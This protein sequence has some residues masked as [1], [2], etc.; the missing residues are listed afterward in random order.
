MVIYSPFIRLLPLSE[1][2]STHFLFFFDADL[3]VDIRKN[4]AVDSGAFLLGDALR[5]MHQDYVHLE[6]Q[7][8]IE[9]VQ[10]RSR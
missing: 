8:G 10:L 9:L 7:I 3:F 1:S 5:A 2:F 6:C 4:A